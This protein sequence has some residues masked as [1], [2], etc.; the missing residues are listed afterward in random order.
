MRKFIL[1]Q[2]T[3]INLTRVDG[4]DS[5]SVL[6]II[7]EIGID[8]NPWPSAKHFGSWLGLAPGT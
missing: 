8:M 1:Q 6:R 4:L 2:M 3:G 5:H 7:S